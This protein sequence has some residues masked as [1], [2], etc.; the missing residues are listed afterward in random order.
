MRGYGVIAAASV[1]WGTKRIFAKLAYEFDISPETI[2]ALGLV[3]SFSTLFIFLVPFD[4]SALGIHKSNVVLFILLGVLATTL[5]R[6]SYFYAVYLT[7]ATMAAIQIYTYPVFVTLYA[8][9]KLK[10]R[11][12]LNEWGVICLTF[13][14]V[15][16][17]VSVYDPTL[18]TVSIIGVFF[19]LLSSLLFVF[20][21]VATKNLRRTYTSWSLTVY[22]DGIGALTLSPI[23]FSSFTQ[24]QDYLVELWYLI[25]AM[26]WIPSRLVY[27]L[28]A[29][30]LKYVKVSK[31]GILSVIE[32]LTAAFSMMILSDVLEGRQIIEIILAMIGV[33]LLF[34][35]E[36]AID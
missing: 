27:L 13:F 25:I 21:F 32:P 12:T 15:A 8:S 7:T 36:K 19:G 16:L 9:Y 2:I 22:G 20:Y 33:I 18:L 35:G 1:L 23:I 24:I 29:T 30:A 28:Y 17:V 14:G 4:R 31:R 11:V 10:E 5:Q 26:A 3:I 34:R 6:I